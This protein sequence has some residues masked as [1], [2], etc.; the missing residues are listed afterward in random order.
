MILSFLHTEYFL[1]CVNRFALSIIL[2]YILY[3]SIL[4]YI[5]LYYIISEV[6]YRHFISAGILSG[7]LPRLRSLTCCG[8]R[9]DLSGNTEET[10]IHNAT[11]IYT[12]CITNNTR[13][14]IRNQ[15]E[16]RLIMACLSFRSSS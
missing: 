2:Q 5:V 9:N 11:C 13:E 14:W 10:R 12:S 16:N 8:T 15:Y 4:Y 3:Y 6:Y 1:M 7:I